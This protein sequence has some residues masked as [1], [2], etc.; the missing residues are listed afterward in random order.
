[1]VDVNVTP[2]KR[3]LFLENEQILLAVIK[4][5]LL[6]MYQK[7][8]QNFDAQNLLPGTQRGIKRNND[9]SSIKPFVM[10]TLLEKRIKISDDKVGNLSEVS[11]DEEKDKSME[12]VACSIKIET[13]KAKV[14]EFNRIKDINEVEFQACDSHLDT[15]EKENLRNV[16]EE[17]KPKTIPSE[18]SIEAEVSLDN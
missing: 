14:I 2:D 9:D 5:S 16:I 12:F 4:S 15:V 17:V 1:M 6:K 10:R 3:K 13:P 18:E 11:S 8:I 7:N